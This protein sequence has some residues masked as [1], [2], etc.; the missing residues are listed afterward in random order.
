ME[1]KTMMTCY[2]ND[3]PLQNKK[4]EKERKNY[5]TISEFFYF[6]S[7]VTKN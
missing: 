2:E 3:F 5:M 4:K 1:Q 6:I 7:D